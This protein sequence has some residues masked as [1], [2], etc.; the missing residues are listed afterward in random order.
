MGQTANAA[1]TVHLRYLSSVREKTG[2][3]S[4]ELALPAGSALTAVASWLAA[5]Y[6][7]QVPGPSLM[8]TLNGRGW[9]QHA[10]GLDQELHDGD[11]IA[12]FPMLSGG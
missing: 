8:A 9:S 3:R 12:L 4:E 5:T 11:E 1:I 6:A 2:R 10:A 7:L